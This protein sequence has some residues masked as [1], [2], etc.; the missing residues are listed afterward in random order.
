MNK[1]VV[2]ITLCFALFSININA[3][4]YQ[5]LQNEVDSL[6]AKITKLETKCKYLEIQDKITRLTYDIKCLNN[7]FSSY[8]YMLSLVLDINGK[9][10]KSIRKAMRE[11]AKTYRETLDRFQKT[12]DQIKDS[13]RFDEKSDECFSINW[14][15]F[16]LTIDYRTAERNLLRLEDLLDN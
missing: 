3:Q 14:D 9:I 12:I 10:D 7:E 5:V 2:I 1:L 6:N 16:I 13:N 11:L 15:L 8:N 4:D